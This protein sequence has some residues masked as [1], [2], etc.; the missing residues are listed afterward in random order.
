ML[1]AVV[2][3]DSSG[4]VPLLDADLE[5]FLSK[6]FRQVLLPTHVES[7]LRRGSRKSGALRRRAKLRR[8]LEDGSL[9]RCR[10]YPTHLVLLWHAELGSSGKRQK[11]RGEAEALAQCQVRSADGILVG[12]KRASRLARELE[13]EVFSAD[14]VVDYWD[15]LSPLPPDASSRWRPQSNRQ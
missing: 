8:L 14:A 3:A 1:A 4:L 6:V 12:E 10:D 13:L 2:V 9:V 11:N 15:R 5:D 7:E